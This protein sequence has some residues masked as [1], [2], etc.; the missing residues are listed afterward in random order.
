MERFCKDAVSVVLLD[1][2]RSTRLPSPLSFSSK[3]LRVMMSFGDGKEGY[4]EEG[5]IKMSV[6]LDV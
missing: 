1:S 5:Q 6:S 4:K 2:G 3:D